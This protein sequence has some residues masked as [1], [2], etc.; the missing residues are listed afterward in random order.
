MAQIVQ[1]AV[2][3]C[4]TG[5]SN[6]EYRIW[7]EKQGTLYAVKA[8]YGRIDACT[9]GTT[10]LGPSTLGS[11]QAVYEKTVDQKLAK[12]YYSH[13]QGTAKWAQK[14]ATVTQSPPKPKPKKKSKPKS[15]PAAK[16]K[17]DKPKKP[18]RSL[19]T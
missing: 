7:I 11:A 5:T 14:P 1:Q 18:K 17:P 8:L 19:L 15:K 2:L 10:K 12:G 13:E 6:K 4:T 3:R 9:N 16:K